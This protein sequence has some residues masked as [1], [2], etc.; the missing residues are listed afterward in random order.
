V[1]NHS[2]IDLTVKSNEEMKPDVKEY[3]LRMARDTSVKNRY[4]LSKNLVI[5][6]VSPILMGTK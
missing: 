1:K 4:K 6:E 2:F 5:K 3:L